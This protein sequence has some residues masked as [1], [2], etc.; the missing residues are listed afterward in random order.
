M[1][2]C[3][4]FKL[5]QTSRASIDWHSS[6]FHA[7][8]HDHMFKRV[9]F[10]ISHVSHSWKSETWHRMPVSYATHTHTHLLISLSRHTI[11][12]KQ[13]RPWITPTVLLL[14]TPSIHMADGHSNT[15]TYTSLNYT[16]LPISN[17][18]ATLKDG[19]SPPINE[20]K[21][22][23]VS[24]RPPP[25]TC[26]FSLFQINHTYLFSPHMYFSVKSLTHMS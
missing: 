10:I 11:T 15:Y 4:L 18:A 22:K 21:H 5:L 26:L 9:I 17:T 8:P 25:P 1:G 3:T 19:A 13:P 12:T 23:R 16:N 24:T 2:A 20:T 7:A 14:F 6:H